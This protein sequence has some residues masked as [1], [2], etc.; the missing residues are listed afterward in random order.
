MKNI[1]PCYLTKKVKEYVTSLIS[2]YDY[3]AY[4]KLSNSDK[5][6]FVAHLI[7]AA[8]RSSE[9]EF[10]TE[11]DYLDQTIFSFRQS[12][13]GMEEDDENFVYTMKENAIR[14]FES[15]METIFESILEDY[16]ADIYSCIK[17]AAL[18]GNPDDRYM[19][20]SL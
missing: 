10:L 13:L 4:D 7:E 6:V 15:T 20:N 18:Y 14:Y 19:E 3:D 2:D 5:C 8:G 11:S 12:L 1:N 9:H 17:H 16:Q